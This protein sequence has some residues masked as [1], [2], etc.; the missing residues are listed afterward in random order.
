MARRLRDCGGKGK[1]CQLSL[2]NGRVWERWLTDVGVTGILEA[3]VWVCLYTWRV[4]ESM[5]KY[6]TSI[7]CVLQTVECCYRFLSLLLLVFSLFCFLLG[8]GLGMPQLCAVVLIEECNCTVSLEKGYNHDQNSIKK[9][10][11]ITQFH[12]QAHIEHGLFTLYQ[13]IVKNVN[14]NNYEITAWSVKL[15]VMTTLPVRFVPNSPL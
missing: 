13:E 5:N 8:W 3:D 1:V 10:V 4:Y 12:S 7:F 15:L 2:G 6:C 9:T 14:G 11:K